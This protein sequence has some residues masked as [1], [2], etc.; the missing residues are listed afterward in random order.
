R[1]RAELRQRFSRPSCRAWRREAASRR[2]GTSRLWRGGGRGGGGGGGP[3]GGQTPGG[4]GGRGG[5][6]GE[7]G[8][9][10]RARAR[11]EEGG[12]LREESAPRVPAGSGGAGANRPHGAVKNAPCQDHLVA[13]LP[14]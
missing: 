11:A 3:R 4:G 10:A 8:G 7:R 9:G 1:C 6:R 14:R 12:A 13:A 2:A 5:G